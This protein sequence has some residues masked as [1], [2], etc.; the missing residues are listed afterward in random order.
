MITH[1]ANEYEFLVARSFQCHPYLFFNTYTIWFEVLV[2]YSTFLWLWYN[3]I[4]FKKHSLLSNTWLV[5]NSP[6][7][8]NVVSHAYGVQELSSSF[9]RG[10][11]AYN[12]GATNREIFLRVMFFLR[13]SHSQAHHSKASRTSTLL[14]LESQLKFSFVPSSQLRHCNWNLRG[15]LCSRRV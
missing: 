10:T 1:H 8:V 4:T 15:R 12:I 9:I 7:L 3:I 5:W 13:H 14:L 2:L 11:L 6:S